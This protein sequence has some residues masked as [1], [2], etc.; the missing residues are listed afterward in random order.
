MNQSEAPD[1]L[2]IFTSVA[3][4]LPL[5]G[6]DFQL[7]E[8]SKEYFKALRYFSL[9][10]VKAGAEQCIAE[11]KFFPKPVEWS[12]RI[13]R[14]PPG[15]ELPELSPSESSEYLQAELRRWEGEPCRCGPCKQAGVDHRF[16]RY[17]PTFDAEDRE[18][19]VRI[20]TREICRGHWA[21]GEE[22]RRYY[23]ARDKFWG[24]FHE[25]TE[26]MSME[27]KRKKKQSFEERIEE[28][29][30]PRPKPLSEY[31]EGNS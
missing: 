2:A 22:L 13:P 18:M 25:F 7:S 11:L 24:E 8:I 4:V 31:T 26:K 3:R 16:L 21:H 6:E 23:E 17:V 15:E 14:R 1:F 28:I 9:A 29:F 20:G 5:K 27:K 10:Q 30:K 19:R 12:R